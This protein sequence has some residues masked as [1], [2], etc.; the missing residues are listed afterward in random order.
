MIVFIN[1]CGEWRTALA[2]FV[3]ELPAVIEHSCRFHQS[4]ERVESSEP[5]DGNVHLLVAVLTLE[6]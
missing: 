5:M 4:S 6:R 3:R 1:F 2:V